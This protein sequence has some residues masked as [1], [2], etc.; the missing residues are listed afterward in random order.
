LGRSGFGFSINFKRLKKTGTEK[1]TM[2]P[3][4]HLQDLLGNLYSSEAL[5]LT[6]FNVLP[7]PDT[8]E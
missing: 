1:L 4:G 7:Y 3:T 8:L 2:S 6:A 5:K